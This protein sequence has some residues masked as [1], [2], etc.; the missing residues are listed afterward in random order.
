M[1]SAETAQV[2]DAQ[3][4]GILRPGRPAPGPQRLRDELLGDRM[5]RDVFEIGTMATQ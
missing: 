4:H 2:E 5:V 3:Q 1:L